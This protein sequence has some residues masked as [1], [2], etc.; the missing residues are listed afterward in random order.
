M[1]TRYY[2]I[3]FLGKSPFS[4]KITSSDMV[5]HIPLLTSKHLLIRSTA[6]TS[7]TGQSVR[8]DDCLINNYAAYTRDFFFFSF[9]RHLVNFLFE[10][11]I[12][13]SYLMSANIFPKCPKISPN[14]PKCPQMSTNAH[15]CSQMLAELPPVCPNPPNFLMSALSHLWI[16]KCGQI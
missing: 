10:I 7:W 5:L 16:V 3:I 4:W 11:R 12:S 2:S 14:V 9:F 6:N 1:G 15:K 13:C 8:I